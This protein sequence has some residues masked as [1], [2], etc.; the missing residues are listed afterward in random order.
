ML[1]RMINFMPGP[2]ELCIG[3]IVAVIAVVIGEIAAR[4]LQPNAMPFEETTGCGSKLDSELRNLTGREKFFAVQ[5]MAMP[6]PHHP[7]AHFESRAIGSLIY[8]ADEKN[9]IQG[10]RGGV[11]HYLR[12]A[13]HLDVFFERRPPSW[14]ADRLTPDAGASPGPGRSS[15]IS[16]ASRAGM[17]RTSSSP[18][19]PTE[20]NTRT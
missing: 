7:I 20:W 4:D 9:R 5:G 11:E 15:T 16:R 12:I 8:E 19:T 1:C 17:R 2:N 10:R 3:Q 18:S 6:R 13:H 14:Y